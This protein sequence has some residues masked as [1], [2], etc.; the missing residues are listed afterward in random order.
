MC[1]SH[2]DLIQEKIF[3]TLF[4]AEAEMIQSSPDTLDIDPM[5]QGREGKVPNSLQV[6]A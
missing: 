6:S 3:R 2:R 1:L 4:S 5:G